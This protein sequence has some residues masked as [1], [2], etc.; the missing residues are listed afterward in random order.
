MERAPIGRDVLLALLVFTGSAAIFSI[1]L[2]RLPFPDE[3]YHVLAARGLLETGEPRIADG[4]YWRGY[5][6]TWL[7]AWSFWLFGEGLA[8][9]RIPSVLF[10]AGLVAALF[11]WLRAR[12][13]STIALAGA[14]FYALSPFAIAIAQ[15][16]RFYALQTLFFFV[17]AVA[18]AEAANLDRPPRRRLAFLAVGLPSLGLAIHLQPVSTIGGLGIALYLAGALLV[19]RLVDPALPRAERFRLLFALSG[20]LVLG[21]GVSAG[22][23]LLGEAWSRF[24]HAETFNAHLANQFWYYHAWYQLL[25]PTLW[26]ATGLLALAAFA[27][28]TRPAALA[29]AVFATAFTLHSLAAPKSLRYIAYAHPFLIVLWTLGLA[30]VWSTLREGLSGLVA[31]VAARLELPTT[32]RSRLAR[33]LVGGAIVFLVL[34]NPAWLRSVT[35]LADI[36]IPPERPPVDWPKAA[37]VLAPHLA[38]GRFVSTSEELGTLYFLGRFDLTLNASR[39]DEIVRGTGPTIVRDPRTGR[40]VGRDLAATRLVLACRA[41]GIFISLAQ[42]WNDAPQIIAPAVKTFLLAHSRPLELPA[43]SGLVAFLWDERSGAAADCAELEPVAL[44][45]D[46]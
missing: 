13:G 22:A 38:S 36:A 8:T 21:L 2:D 37:P 35:L 40:G 12:V 9:A 19:P 17:A 5:L 32:M 26:P 34:A 14:V 46:G 42:F 18:V 11:W 29:L 1:N 16:C 6:Q 39:Y 15:F 33:F 23:G 45:H 41:P 25:F 7:T 24:R 31:G 4:L 44:R 10:T 3:L 30:A 20:L 27:R 28:W 43:G